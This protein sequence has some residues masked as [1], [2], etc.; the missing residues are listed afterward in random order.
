MKIT[1]PFRIAALAALCSCFLPGCRQNPDLLKA[2]E[3]IMSTDR[4]YSAMSARTGMNSAFLA[5][6]DSNGVILQKN[7]YPVEGIRNI[8]KLLE[9]DEDS[10]F[11]L[12]WE[13]L[14]AR[15]AISGEI[16]Y[17]YG[18]YAIMGKTSREKLSEGTYVTIWG[19]RGE[20][21]WKALLDT[22]N[23]GLSQAPKTGQ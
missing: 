16:G 4:E 9:S 8:R 2:T 6:F 13:P 17:T 3:S 14:K 23:P 19:R 12:T 10:S 7:H 11:I 21:G 22:G 1:R 20:E 15:V 18:T 5:M